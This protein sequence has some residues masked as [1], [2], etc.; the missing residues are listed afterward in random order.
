MKVLAALLVLAAISAVAF[1][2]QCS[3]YGSCTPCA[4]DSSCKW[5]RS[6]GG[7]YDLSTESGV[8]PD[9]DW[10]VVAS[11]CLAATPT[12]AANCGR[13]S[14]C[15]TCADDANCMWCKA[16]GRCHALSAAGSGVCPGSD[17]AIVTTQCLAATPTPAQAACGTFTAC[18]TCAD[19]PSCKWCKSGGGCYA[20][21]ISTGCPDG[22]W[23]YGVSGCAAAP[24]PTPAANCGRYATCGACTA[25]IGC[26]WC[27][28]TGGCFP[29][30]AGAESCPGTDWAIVTAQCLA[31]TPTPTPTPTPA[32]T[33][34]PGKALPCL[35]GL[36]LA[37][38]LGFAALR[39][40]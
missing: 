1:A 5:C 6:W 16:T 12:P 3:S 36:V 9:E 34:T 26:K 20:L 13:Y 11:E 4:D 30:S 15:A 40:D 10:A 29:L 23:A 28:G 8:C 21:G 35:P 18:A 19:Q 22:D 14:S 31:A 37:A 17:W 24:T 32:P 27:R 38:A 7:C 2:V 39:R 25:D 33:P